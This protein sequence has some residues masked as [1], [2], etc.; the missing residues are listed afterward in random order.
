MASEVPLCASR[1]RRT[2]AAVTTKASTSKQRVLLIDDDVRLLTSLRRA[3]ELKGFT[4]MT[5]E[6]AGEAVPLLA[7]QPPN[8]VVLDVAMPGMDG[9]TFCGLIRSRLTVPILMLTARD[10]VH[11]RVAGLEAGADDYLIKPFALDE[12]VARIRALLR[13]ILDRPVAVDRLIYDDVH[14]DRKTWQASR[15]GRV[16]PLTA[17]EFLLLEVLLTDPER[18]FSRDELLQAA[19]REAVTIESNVVD[20]HIANLR[21]KLEA[22]GSVP[23][24]RT[25]R[26]VGYSLKV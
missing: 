12:L 13:R 25:I 2:K 8:I 11:D 9:L 18:V 14:L 7:A 17:T 19:W 22:A 5:A 24:I 10:E 4:V 6:S 21:R 23:L 26:R 15:A 16:L 20:V 1:R 3:L